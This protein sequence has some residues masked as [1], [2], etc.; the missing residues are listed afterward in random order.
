MA[1]S[2]SASAKPNWGK[3]SAVVVRLR[4]RARAKPLLSGFLH[5]LLYRLRC[6]A[7][8]IRVTSVHCLDCVGAHLQRPGRKASQAAAQLP[9]SQHGSTL[10]ERDGSSI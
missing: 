6:A 8:E 10:L 5:H 2:P 3:A 9:G 1:N 7:S 4:D